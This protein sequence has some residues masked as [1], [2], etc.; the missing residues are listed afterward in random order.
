M[1]FKRFKSTSILSRFKAEF[2]E[3]VF[4][5]NKGRNAKEFG[6]ETGRVLALWQMVR[7]HGKVQNRRDT[8]LTL[9]V[10]KDWIK[11]LPASIYLMLPGTFLTVP[12]IFRYVP[13]VLPRF[14]ITPTV[15]Q[16]RIRENT[17][18]VLKASKEGLELIK[19]HLQSLKVQDS[20]EKHFKDSLLGLVHI[21]NAVGPEFSY[22]RIPMGSALTIYSHS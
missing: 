12:L 14:L 3:L 22:I 18:Q 7:E 9:N 11:A 1:P 13:G 10:K 8:R 4:I 6:R 21:I 19:M 2:G 16:I 20:Q 5:T 17:A 15:N